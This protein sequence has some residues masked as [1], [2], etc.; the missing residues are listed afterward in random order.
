MSAPSRLR[1]DQ[2]RSPPSWPSNGIAKT[3]T[4]Q[5]DDYKYRSIDDVLDRLAPLLAE[6]P[7]VRASAGARAIVTERRDEQDRLLLHVAL[8]V[9]FTLT[10]VEDGSS[11]TSRLMARRWT[12]ATRRPP[13]RCRRRTRRDDADLLHPGLPA[14]RIPT[15]AA[16]GWAQDARARSRVQGWEQWCRDI[17]DIVALCE[18]EQ[19]IR[20]VSRSAT[21]ISSRRSLA[22]NRSS[23]PSSARH[24]SPGGRPLA[25]RKAQAKREKRLRGTQR[26]TR[27]DKGQTAEVEHA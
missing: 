13:R 8:R 7:A 11:H 22:S 19:A 6:A 16:I 3:R 15:A 10:S 2:R 5:V 25:S 14:P 24:S 17:E 4:N 9:A 1:R 26:R 27:I 23:M 21:A 18:S 12:P 20:C